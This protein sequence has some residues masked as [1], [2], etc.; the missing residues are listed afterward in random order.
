MRL[1]VLTLKWSSR[2]P[3]RSRWSPIHGIALR[4]TL[5]HWKIPATSSMPDCRKRLNAIIPGSP[6][7]ACAIDDLK[8]LSLM[9]PHFAT[10]SPPPVQLSEQVVQIQKS[11]ILTLVLPR[12]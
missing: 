9:T 3:L 1:A 6:S 8:R 11:H 4:E 10:A 12:P 7:K 5:S 2:N